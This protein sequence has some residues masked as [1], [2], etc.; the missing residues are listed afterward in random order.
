MKLP[1]AITVAA[2]I[3]GWSIASAAPSVAA[4]KPAP[5]GAKAPNVVLQSVIDGK[6][7]T[8]D[9]QAAAAKR[10]VVLYFFPQAFSAG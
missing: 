1:I 2:A 5:P 10:P 9:L 8:Y 7:E 3:A 6:I 4:D